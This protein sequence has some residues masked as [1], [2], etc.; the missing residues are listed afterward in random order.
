[1]KKYLLLL[2]SLIFLIGCEKEKPKQIS[3]NEKLKFSQL[4]YDKAFSEIFI[5]NYLATLKKDTSF[6]YLDTLRYF[7]AHRDFKP[8]FIKSFDQKSFIDSLLHFLNKSWEHGLD[9]EL[10]HLTK[11]KNEF[12]KS[13]NDSINSPARYNHLANTELFVCDAIIKYAYHLRYG[14]VEPGIILFRSYFLP[15]DSSKKDLFQP[16]KQINVISYLNSIQ[17]KNEK[18]KRLQDALKKYIAYKDVKWVI[19]PSTDKKIEPGNAS[20]IIAPVTERLITLGYMDTS[21][22]KIK[23]STFYDSLLIKPI[24]KFQLQNGLNDDG[25][26]GKTTIDKLNTSPEE[27]INKI[28][29]NL[30]RLRWNNYSDTSTYIAVNIPDFRLYIVDNKKLIYNIKVCT[31][32]R[33]PPN[34]EKRYKYYEKTKRLWDRPD[35]WQTPCLYSRISTVVLN[36]TW[37]VPPN[38]IREEILAGLRKD[39]SYLAKRNFKVYKKGVEISPYDVNINDLRIENIPYRIVQDPGDGNALGKIKFLFKNPF[40]V[41]L[42]D[43]PQRAAFLK[44]NRA[45]S[46]G[47]I[48]VEKPLQLAEFLLRG[49]SKWNMDYLKIEIGQRIT[50]KAKIT[51]YQ[52]KRNELRKNSGSG[53]T[54]EIILDTRIPLFVDYYTSW[55]DENGNLN[56]R[57][58]VYNQDRFLS[59]YLFPK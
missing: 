52:K 26:I 7:Y 37:S 11:I 14:A 38:I 10:Y 30:E 41:Y 19:I 24:R 33:R 54:T 16:L 44:S 1:V 57:D 28:K 17:P 59:E 50:D 31:G 20:S 5:A 40:G 27:Y 18:Y 49:H 45:V 39:S 12:Y 3:L 15:V 8:L 47:C 22:I 55:V 46:H 56:F 13:L 23:N 58:D 42:H 4:E 43:T 29:I 2:F 9:C 6:K 34:F 48:R 35:D 53:K 32:Q 36:P 25:V 51:E 21:K